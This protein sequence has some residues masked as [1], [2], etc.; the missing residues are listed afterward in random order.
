[1]R[2]EHNLLRDER[3]NRDALGVREYGVE[4]S[5]VAGYWLHTVHQLVALLLPVLY[6]CELFA[7]QQS[8]CRRQLG[9]TE[10]AV[11]LPPNPELAAVA[12]VTEQDFRARVLTRLL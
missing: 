3:D 10:I 11:V 2:T 4:L 1:M 12:V 6:H 9:P 5:Q 7:L 8:I